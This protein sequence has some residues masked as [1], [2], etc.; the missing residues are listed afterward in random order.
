MYSGQGT[1]Y[2]KVHID[3]SGVIALGGASNADV[4]TSTTDE[5][6]RID[7]NGVKIYN[8][9]SNYA[10]VSSSGMTIVG[11]SDIQAQFGLDGVE[12]DPKLTIG[13]PGQARTVITTDNIS[14]YDGQSTPR[15]RVHIDSSGNAAFGG[16]AG[17]D[18]STTTTDDIIR[19]T[20]GS[21]VK[22]FDSSTDYTHMS[23]DGLK[24][25]DGDASNPVGVFGATTYV[26]LQA[27]EHIKITN[28]KFELKRGSE[29]FASAS[30][31]GF[32]ASG[33]LNAGHG[34][35][36]GFRINN[37]ELVDKSG[38]LSLSS[39]SQSLLISGS[40]GGMGNIIMTSSFGSPA[41]Q[42][43]LSMGGA[44][45]GIYLDGGRIDVYNELDYGTID[46]RQLTA[47]IKSLDSTYSEASVA[48][49]NP[50]LGPGGSSFQHKES[51]I[52]FHTVYAPI[53]AAAVPS[54]PGQINV[55]GTGTLRYLPSVLVLANPSGSTYTH[56]GSD[57]SR[58]IALQA[59]VSAS[60]VGENPTHPVAGYF[61]GGSVVINPF[62]SYTAD[63]DALLESDVPLVVK[64]QNAKSIRLTKDTN[65]ADYFDI[66]LDDNGE[67]VFSE[68]GGTAILT[69]SDLGSATFGG[70][71]TLA[72]NA[73][74][75]VGGAKWKFDD[76]GDDITTQ[77][78]VGIGTT[79]TPEE[80]TVEGT[81][82]G[83]SYL[84]VGDGARDSW[85]GRVHYYHDVSDSTFR[86]SNPN[87][88]GYG[89]VIRA[90]TSGKY[91][92][93][94][95]DYN[96]TSRFLF[97]GDGSTS[98]ADISDERVKTNITNFDGDA[99][100]NIKALSP[101]I[102]TFKMDGHDDTWNTYTG[103]IAQH[104]TGSTTESISRLVHHLEP[105]ASMSLSGSDHRYY[106]DYKGLTAQLIRA[107]AQLEARV[108]EL[109]S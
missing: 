65:N 93:R 95:Y 57:E 50:F 55:S 42:V 2:R 94:I 8:D 30:S 18:G 90:G 98:P 73:T 15:R 72:N 71:I 107:V 3:S 39:V 78:N 16:A 6:V 64:A 91:S 37:N 102:K 53:A 104:I 101:K 17:A 4:S 27:S 97:Y 56:A 19:I 21:G 76:T 48:G 11:G 13:V 77:G 35:I 62:A 45:E 106:L 99:L 61:K 43:R 10:F 80:L 59:E 24:I 58:I 5:V 68:N 92:L 9:S 25:Y 79:E 85:A 20:P 46:V 87:S 14:M 44:N 69:L 83:S 38:S 36:G 47:Y 86:I 40:G 28:S 63:V 105:E 96:L 66:D 51:P 89:P 67:L 32:Y 60:G 26:G 49:V 1:P 81:I 100:S 109:E 88:A 7:S 108:A 74:V 12:G 75:G 82:S 84:Y 34:T 23:A 54:G 22:I 70:N 31:A 33:S 103:L 41:K 52:Q 29:V